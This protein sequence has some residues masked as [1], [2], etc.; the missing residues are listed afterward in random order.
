[1]VRIQIH[2]QSS[3]QLDQSGSKNAAKFIVG[4]QTKCL[5]WFLHCMMQHRPSSACPHGA[6]KEPQA[7]NRAPSICPGGNGMLCWCLRPDELCYW[8]MCSTPSQCSPCAR[9][10]TLSVAPGRNRS[11]RSVALVAEW[12]SAGQAYSLSARTGGAAVGSMGLEI[13]GWVDLPPSSRRP[14]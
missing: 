2:L 8:M 13:L 14:R 12:L 9:L 10:G 1:M 4:N 5:S 3:K 6:K 7:T 11:W